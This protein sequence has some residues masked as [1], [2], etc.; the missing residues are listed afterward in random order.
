MSTFT[1]N[2]QSHAIWVDAKGNKS[3]NN[4]AFLTQIQKRTS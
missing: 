2:S 3:I 1:N 4:P